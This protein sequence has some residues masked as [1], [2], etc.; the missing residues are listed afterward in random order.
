MP[1]TRPGRV[2]W[3]SALDPGAGTERAYTPVVS[4]GSAGSRVRT[5]ELSVSVGGP[6]QA[7]ASAWL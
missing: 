2:A 6:A 4:V 5:G 7:E 3:G 1:R